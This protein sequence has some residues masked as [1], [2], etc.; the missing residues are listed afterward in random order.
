MTTAETVTWNWFYGI[1]L[2]L[3]IT[4]VRR[5]SKDVLSSYIKHGSAGHP[6]QVQ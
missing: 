1:C 4:E 3:F 6:G 5:V 2:Y